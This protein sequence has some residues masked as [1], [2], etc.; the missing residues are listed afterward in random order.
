MDPRS[1][2]LASVATLRG[3]LVAAA[4]AAVLIAAALAPGAAAA[5]RGPSSTPL[6]LPHRLQAA[7][8]G[9]GQ[10]WVNDVTYQLWGCAYGRHRTHLLQS[11][12]AGDFTGYGAVAM[13]G[14]YV[15]VE[16][17]GVSSTGYAEDEICVFD[18]LD[19]RQ[20][21]CL[22][23]ASGAHGPGGGLVGSMV[24][25]RDGSIAWIATAPGGTNQPSYGGSEVYAYDAHGYRLVASGTD[26]APGSLALAGN[27]I[28]WMQ[29]GV[30]RS[31]RLA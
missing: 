3:F 31:S 19:G 11:L 1:S 27:R 18:V 16:S 21:A 29:G 4:S 6:C 22:G 7:A 26:I 8:D 5:S 15:A 28:Y 25:K 20:S 2:R 14:H 17:Y 23:D 10:V 24:V 30:A 9:F 13:A 12:G